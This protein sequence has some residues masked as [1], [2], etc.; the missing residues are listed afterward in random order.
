VQFGVAG[1]LTRF[2]DESKPYLWNADMVLSASLKSDQNG[3]SLIQQRH[4]LRFDTLDLLQGRLRMDTRASFLRTINAG[5]YGLGNTSTAE[6]SP[7]ETSIGRRYQYVHQEGRVRV[8]GRVKMAEALSFAFGANIRDEIPRAYASSKLAEDAAARNP[9]GTPVIR[10]LEPTALAGGAVGLVY[11]TR[12][13]EFVT[14]SGVFYEVGAGATG[15]S[16]GEANYGSASAILSHF[17]PIWGPI[18]FANRFVAAFEFGKVP[19]YDLAQG[20]TFEPQYLLGGESGIRGVPQA[21]YSGLIKV[22]TNVEMRTVLPRFYLLRQR[23]R[24]GTTTFVDAGRVWNDYRFDASRDGTKLNL[25]YGVGGGLFLQ[26][27]EAAIFRLEAAYSPDAVAEN[28]G[29]PIGIYV[30]DGLMF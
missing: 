2:W 8:I 7:G 14:R 17:A 16:T 4:L 22:L 12:D 13:T 1:T 26:W 15:S 27:G 23:L 10:G 28:P 25:K 3:F 30:T 5:Y 9:D 20:G 24:V 29:L 18:S 21:R 6:P 19:F 11:D